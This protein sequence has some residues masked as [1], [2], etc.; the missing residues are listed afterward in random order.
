MAMDLFLN[1]LA[2]KANDKKLVLYKY[3]YLCYI[4]YFGNNAVLDKKLL[5]KL[6]FPSYPSN[7]V[8]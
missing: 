1:L 7:G 4:G 5:T 6:I 2:I 8:I 3:S